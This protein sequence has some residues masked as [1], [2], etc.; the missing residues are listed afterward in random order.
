[1][2]VIAERLC[3]R[4]IVPCHRKGLERCRGHGGFCQGDGG[5]TCPPT[6]TVSRVPGSGVAVVP[7]WTDAYR[8]KVG[9]TMK[10]QQTHFVIDADEWITG[11]NEMCLV[12]IG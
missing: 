7:G 3:Q 2:P 5:L 4:N 9:K 12:Y 10:K 6:V 1:M 8:Y 11:Y